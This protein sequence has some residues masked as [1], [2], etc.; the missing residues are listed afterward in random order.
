MFGQRLKKL[1]ES[2][3]ITQSELA[4]ALK[5]SPSTI[6]MYEQSRRDPDTDT[7]KLLANY[8]NV[9]TD[10]L[11]GHSDNPTTIHELG[12]LGAEGYIK[13]HGFSKLAEATRDYSIKN[14]INYIYQA[15]TLADALLRLVELDFEYNFDDKTM[16]KLVRKAREKYGLPKINGSEPAAHGP[17]VPGSGVFS[18]K[19]DKEGDDN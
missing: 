19:G 7:I 2:R 14:D 17:K 1:R 16:Y 9:T 3:G 15:K 18:R 12:D 8:F 11:I 5:V 13:K 4:K 10:Y 6:G